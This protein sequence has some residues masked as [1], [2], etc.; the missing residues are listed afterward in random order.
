MN[1]I[2]TSVWQNKERTVI[3]E[4]TKANF[5]R[6]TNQGKLSQIWKNDGSLQDKYDKW[7][8]EVQKITKN[9]SQQE[10][11]KGKRSTEQ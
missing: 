1:W 2:T 7:T 9:I 3:N 5:K 6:E 10:K 11:R 8:T 4:H